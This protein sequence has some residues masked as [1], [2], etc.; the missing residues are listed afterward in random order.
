MWLKPIHILTFFKC[1]VFNFVLFEIQHYTGIKY[2]HLNIKMFSTWLISLFKQYLF[3]LF[4]LLLSNQAEIATLVQLYLLYPSLL[5]RCVEFCVLVSSCATLL[6]YVYAAMLITKNI[7]K[8]L[9]NGYKKNCG[10]LS[11]LSVKVAAV[12]RGLQGCVIVKLWLFVFSVWLVLNHQKESRVSC[13]FVFFCAC[14]SPFKV[15][16]EFLLWQ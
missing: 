3:L 4:K 2:Q 13:F 12:L 10:T 15:S 9:H 11:R 14:L 16:H 5:N 8:K 6:P 7:E 1:L